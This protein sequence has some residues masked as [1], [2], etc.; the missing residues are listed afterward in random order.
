MTVGTDPVSR[1]RK[2]SNEIITPKATMPIN[3]RQQ[4]SSNSNVPTEPVRA[5]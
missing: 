1:Q 2:V 5:R 3:V 4:T